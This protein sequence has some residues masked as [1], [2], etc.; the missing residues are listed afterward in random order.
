LTTRLSTK[1]QLIIPKEIRDRHGWEPGVPLEIEDRGDH[2][3]VRLA[4][5]DFP[6]TTLEDLIG[7]LPYEGPA[8]S[9][10]EM[11]AAITEA[12]RTRP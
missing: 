2:L 12:A 4:E 11:N 8:H 7:C 3:E 5:Q 9:V 1:G 6:E 10:E